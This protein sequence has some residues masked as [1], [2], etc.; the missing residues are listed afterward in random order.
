MDAE[1]AIRKIQ[2]QIDEI[3]GLMKL[4]RP[5]SCFRSWKRTT[6]LLLK[7]VFG[8]DSSH[9]SEFT[10]IR[11]APNGVISDR[12]IVVGLQR[13]LFGTKVLLESI[14]NEI[15]IHGLPE[16]SEEEIA[17]PESPQEKTE[18]PLE[19]KTA[20]I[21]LIAAVIGLV[22][23]ILTFYKDVLWGSKTANPP[24]R[25]T[26]TTELKTAAKVSPPSRP[27]GASP[28][29]LFEN[30]DLDTIGYAVS[31]IPFDGN[32]DL[33]TILSDVSPVSMDQFFAILNN[34]SIADLKK[35]Q[36]KSKHQGRIVQWAG[37][38]RSVG[39]ILVRKGIT[40]FFVNFQPDLQKIQVF[41]SN[42]VIA[43]F[44]EN[45]KTDLLDLNVLDW[46]EVQG[47]L[48]FF[49]DSFESLELGILDTVTLRE[50]KL[51]WP[52]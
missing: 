47:R 33:D 43:L 2:A 34:D 44:P 31:P 12:S 17:N 25:T 8:K 1:E 11:Y 29:S 45:A 28:A 14:I 15:S 30:I 41:S 10:N 13:G 38:V 3:E 35:S 18:E 23:V 26:T 49:D 48:D 22:T 7:H 51:I 40:E 39:P 16:H 5:N 52:K 9:V 21:I 46:I 4:Q 20:K 19:H 24:E 36:F 32:I 42:R 6:E 37:H 50:S 27:S